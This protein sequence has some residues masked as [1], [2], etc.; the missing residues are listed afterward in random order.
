MA[1]APAAPPRNLRMIVAI[2]VIVGVV[3]AA[4]IGYGVVGYA[5]AASRIS[6]ADSALNSVIDH[7]NAISK[8][9]DD[10]MTALSGVN[11]TSTTTVAELQ[12]ARTSADTL[13]TSS[14]NALPTVAADDASL[15]SAGDK[16]NE[17]QWL[18]VISRDR[19]NKESD[20]LT[21]ARKA[22]ADQKA[23]M[24]DYAQLGQF[25]Q[26]FLDENVDLLTIGDKANANDLTGAVA[27]STQL[28]TDAAKA[29]PLAGAAGLPAEVHQYQVDLEALATDFV[30]FL[31]AA[32]AGDNSTAVSLSSK[33][34]A[35]ATAVDS[36]DW[37]KIGGQIQDFYK[38][39]IDDYNS[40]GH[41]AT[42]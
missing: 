14:Q 42:A 27:A 31:N 9:T 6:N 10:A 1:V 15:V 2:L 40:E 35:E 12:K 33:I 26:A 30:T 16:L 24:T 28:K 34:K 5:Y 41:L 13:V 25:F 7:E 19:V 4:L 8:A 21:H 32:Q 17:Q 22:V 29:L 38:P 3:A 37:S 11:V 39:L 36:H 23:I 20:R 18:M